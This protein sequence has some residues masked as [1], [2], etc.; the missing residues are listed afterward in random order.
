MGLTNAHSEKLPYASL[1]ALGFRVQG[2][3]TFC[4]ISGWNLKLL[5]KNVDRER[6][7]GLARKLVCSSPT[8]LIRISSFILRQM[9][10]SESPGLGFRDEGSGP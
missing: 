5:A 3:G 4:C 1:R 10:P 2:L 7:S 6:P 9:L 8:C